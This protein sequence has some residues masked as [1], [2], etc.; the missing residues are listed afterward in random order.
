MTVQIP[1]RG[2]AVTAM[3]AGAMLIAASAAAGDPSAGSSAAPGGHGLSALLPLVAGSVIRPLEWPFEFDP[4]A[5]EGLRE[6]ANR[7]LEP[8]D[9]E[10]D[11]PSPEALAEWVGALDASLADASLEELAAWAPWVDEAAEE[12]AK[13]PAMRAHAPRLQQLAE[14]YSMVS[15]VERDFQR[16]PRAPA[17]APPEPSPSKPRL[18]PYRMRPGGRIVTPAPPRP[19]PATDTPA[20]PAAE[21]GAGA[22]PAADAATAE[23]ELASVR[24]WKGRVRTRPAYPETDRWLPGAKRAFAAEGVPPELAWMAEVESGWDPAAQSAAGAKGLFQ[25]MPSTAEALGLSAKPPRDERGDPAKNARAAARY[26]KRL[27]ERFGRWP[28]AVAAF[29]GGEGRVA[30]AV[31]RTGEQRFSRLSSA[32]PRETRMYVPRV[33]ATIWLREGI[34]PGT[35]PPPSDQPRPLQTAMRRAPGDDRIPITLD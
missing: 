23:R 3:L 1:G 14:Y 5:L 28:L 4:A 18:G 21:Q 25:L 20:P 11:L 2:N 30:Q 7:L 29:N 32:L 33:Y 35:L 16:W 13:E 6:G 9:Y 8:F 34:D 15:A 19:A 26:L 12:A 24:R 17:P 31:R 10:I 22:P 27:Y